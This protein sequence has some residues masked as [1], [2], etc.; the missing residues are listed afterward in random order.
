VT[1]AVTVLSAA[2]LGPG[3]PG[4]TASR[5]ML[6]GTTPWQSAEVTLPPPSILSATERRRTGPV[7]RL[8]LTVA[9]QA[10]QASGLSA[11]DL[12]TVFGSGNGDALTVGAILEAVTTPDGFVSPTQ[13]HNSVHNAA[14]GYWSIGVGSVRPA[15]CVACGDWTFAASLMKA[16]AE[17][18]IEREP[19][20]LCV[21]DALMPAPLAAA[22]PVT[23]VFGVALVLAPDGPGPRM[24]VQ[25]DMAAA[26]RSQPLLTSLRP[27]AETN[28]AA[29]SLRLLEALAQ[30][31]DHAFDLA[32]LDGRLRVEVTP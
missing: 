25:W 4:W 21:Y 26:T 20:L 18:E 23:S 28:P 16:V 1:V 8:A 14:A 24:T 9:T 10:A 29:R 7:V 27:L 2:I 3:L 15:T 12:R 5:A 31:G 19:V 11:P 22:R 32:F 17:C 6:A 13:F 30:G